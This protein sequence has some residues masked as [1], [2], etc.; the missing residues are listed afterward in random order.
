MKKHIYIY[1]MAVISGAS[2]LIL[3]KFVI[4]GEELKML[5]GLCYGFGSACFALGLGYLT[6]S[7]IIPKSKK[8][9]ILRKK[10]IEVNDERNL[11]IKEKAGAKINQVVFYLLCILI[12]ILG[13]IGADFI[14]ILMVAAILVIELILLIVLTNHYSKIM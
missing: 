5:A 7:L 3:G 8:E 14:V 10:A 13:F 11:R 4:K 6:E 12:L 2:L 1:I 9:E